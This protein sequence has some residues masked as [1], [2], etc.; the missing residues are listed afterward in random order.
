MC[1]Y[2]ALPSS[3]PSLNHSIAHFI[4]ETCNKTFQNKNIHTS[5]SHPNPNG[6]ISFNAPWKAFKKPSIFDVDHLQIK[7]HKSPSP[8]CSFSSLLCCTYSYH[9]PSLALGVKRVRNE[10]EMRVRVWNEVKRDEGI[11][12]SFVIKENK[13]SSPM[14]NYLLTCHIPLQ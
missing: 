2:V 10:M 6:D 3:N 14:I 1:D 4:H 12:N 7:W 5:I 8:K 13:I 11:W 9:K